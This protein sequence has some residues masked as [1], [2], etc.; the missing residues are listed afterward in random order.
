MIGGRNV[1]RSVVGDW[2]PRAVRD[3]AS[4]ET[5]VLKDSTD[6][7]PLLLPAIR[8]D[9]PPCPRL[10][11]LTIDCRWEIRHQ[12]LVRIVRTRTEAGFPLQR[13]I[14]PVESFESMASELRQFVD[15]VECGGGGDSLVGGR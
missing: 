5:L 7:L 1:K 13:V 10:R 2:V 9:K 6:L 4:V 12:G 14:L 8:G 15:G 3:L 11:T